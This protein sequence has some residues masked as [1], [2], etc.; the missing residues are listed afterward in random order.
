MEY[1]KKERFRKGTYNKLKHKM[2]WR[3]KILRKFSTN[4]YEIELPSNLQISLIF[5]VSNIYPFKYSGV[6][7]E[8]MMLGEYITFI[9]WQGQLPKN[10][11]QHI[12]D[13]LDKRVS[14]K[15]KDK[16]CFQYLVKWKY[17]PYEDAVCVTTI[18]ISYYNVN[19]EYLLKNYFLPPEY[20]AGASS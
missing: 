7:V 18:E 11:Q 3:C 6:L 17:Q 14:K 20:D 15:T 16:K 1:I 19:P 8:E 13:I 2:I 4:A 10:E 5:N 9:Y 12:E